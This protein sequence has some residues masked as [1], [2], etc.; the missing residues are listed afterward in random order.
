MA[1]KKK[2]KPLK[3]RN[4]FG[5]HASMRKAVKFKDKRVPRGGAKNKQAEYREED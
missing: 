4:P 5:L 1:K 2:R 3:H